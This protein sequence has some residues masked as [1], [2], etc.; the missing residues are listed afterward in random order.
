MNKFF[1]LY[2][3]INA[4]LLSSVLNNSVYSIEFK[5]RFLC[6]CFSFALLTMLFESKL[7][8]IE[9]EKKKNDGPNGMLLLHG[10]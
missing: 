6:F 7:E 9:K 1:I 4:I 8:D 5:I 10:D 3:L 2:S